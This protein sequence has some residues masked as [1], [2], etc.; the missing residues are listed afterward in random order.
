MHAPFGGRRF[1]GATFYP[2]RDSGSQ[3]WPSASGST[4]IKKG[5]YVSASSRKN[6]S[7]ISL[8]LGLAAWLGQ[9]LDLITEKVA[10]MM[11][12]ASLAMGAVAIFD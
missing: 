9:K 4:G 12:F 8:V 6:L 2:C 5:V 3:A 7:I 11:T 1:D 10:D